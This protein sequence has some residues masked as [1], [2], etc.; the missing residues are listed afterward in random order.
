MRFSV[1]R[2]LI[3]AASFLLPTLAGAQVPTTRPTPEQAQIL[4]QT[5]PDLVAQLRQ[6]FATSGLTA[7]QVR[8]RLRAEGYPENL[9]DAY[10]PGMTGDAPPVSDDVFA[11]VRALGVADSADVEAM[12]EGRSLQY[13][14][15]V[16]GGVVCVV[17]P[18]AGR[19]LPG[20]TYPGQIYPG[21]PTFPGESYP[22]QYYPG[23]PTFPGQE[24]PGQRPPRDTGSQ[25]RQ[26]PTAQ[27]PPFWLPGP[28]PS[29]SGAAQDTLTTTQT[30]P[31]GVPGQVTPATRSMNPCPPG[32]IP[33]RA[34]PRLYDPRYETLLI[35]RD[36]ADRF[37]AL[38]DSGYAVFG[39]DVFRSAN[40]LFDP[41][42][43]GPVDANYRLGP[44]DRLVLILTGDV[45][46]SYQLPVTR[47]GF[48]VIPQVGQVFVANLTLAEFERVL[49]ARLSRVYSGVRADNRGSTQFSVHVARLRSNQVYVVGDVRAP[50]SYVVS[51]AGTALTALYA[52]GGPT[53]NG[54]L[55][56]VQ[57]RRAGRTMEVLDVYDYLVGGDA[58]RDVRLQ[59]GD[60]LFVPVHGARARILG[61]IAR[62]ATYEMKPTETLADLLRA[63]GGFKATASRQRV[64]IERILPPDERTA[65]GRDRVTITVSSDALG[66]A[67]GAA[68]PLQ[69][70]DVVRVFPVAERVRNRI[71]VDG[72]VFLRGAQGLSPNMRLSDALRHAGLKPDTYLGE[73]LVTRLRS[74]S[75]RVQLRATLA[76]TTGAVVNDIPLQEDDQIQVFSLTTFRPVRYVAIGGA[77]RRSGRV[78]YREGMTLRDLVLLANGVQEGAYLKEAEIA[79]LPDDRSGGRTAATIRV[80][81][82]STYLFERGPDGRYI[83]P[84]GM[85]APSG[86]APDVPLKPYDNVLIMRQPDWGLQRS[87]TIQGE[88]KF[89]GVYTLTNKSERLS[90]V[91]KRA[92]G[93]T[94][95]AYADGIIFVR[96]DNNIGRVGVELTSALRRYES[97]DNLIL[98]DG[99]RISIPP[100]NAVVTIRGAVNLP[101]AVAYIRG[102]G[103]DY[104]IGAAGG[105]TPD[106]DEDHAFV[107]QPSG[108]LETVKNHLFLP[109][110]MPK[111]RPGSIVTVPESNGRQEES[112]LPLLSG[113]VQ[114]IGS[115]VAILVAV[116]R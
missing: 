48:V 53:I 77:V 9:L 14:Q 105:P 64:L 5:R 96:R 16:A 33:A 37:A 99:D 79:R 17:D 11:A 30:V 42:L 38:V 97:A 72:N 43:A 75:T 3:V 44:G 60:V 66:T 113:L 86:G 29:P 104:Y 114:I 10:L 71:F 65:T 98:R 22:G 15:T 32:Q 112:I 94:S 107:I 6:R 26:T 56:N 91:V 39:L 95:E 18:Y 101:S 63:A 21:A 115:T 55:R 68:I 88:V 45:E 1:L 25:R 8:A 46:S 93:L 74:D 111:P 20:Q 50:G 35:G 62:P 116:T 81:L 67:S 89:P 23:Q 76:D 110:R 58:S 90:D 40:T 83:G 31:G 27:V 28:I 70:G 73:V 2:S 85:P 61:E 52:A 69:D 34:D 106:A 100:Y 108:K 92:G 51:S 47:E 78:L 7:E 4:L 24:Y 87:V 54:S 103:I 13:P 41:S 19:L 109:D 57:V 102:K 49:A 36:S 59:T 84:P 12:R 82:D 80:P